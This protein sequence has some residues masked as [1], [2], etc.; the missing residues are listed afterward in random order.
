MVCHTWL[1]NTQAHSSPP[2]LSSMKLLFTMSLNNRQLIHL[3]SES[4][5]R[6][7]DL[8]KI[9]TPSQKKIATRKSNVF[10]SAFPQSLTKDPL[11]LQIVQNRQVVSNGVEIRSF[12]EHMRN[13]QVERGPR[14][15]ESQIK[16]AN[17]MIKDDQ[18]TS[19]LEQEK[20][21]N[22]SYSI[23]YNSLRTGVPRQLRPRIWAFLINADKMSELYVCCRERSRWRGTR[24]SRRSSSAT[25]RST[26]SRSRSTQ[27]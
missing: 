14:I 12:F 13:C 25:R 16:N 3:E 4:S 9:E 18:W 11:V 24:S 7:Q 10:S 1:R 15:V 23:L 5:I 17:T 2:V 21:E 26:R 22:I 19:I 27:T 6:E 20:K 8:P